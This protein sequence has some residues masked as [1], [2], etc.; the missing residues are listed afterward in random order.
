V[1]ETLLWSSVSHP[2]FP[3]TSLGVLARNRGINISTNF[4]ISRK[5]PNNPP[6]LVGIFVRQLAIWG[7]LCAVAGVSLFSDL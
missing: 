7:N 3:G 2:G 1:V 5:I 6:N 4:E